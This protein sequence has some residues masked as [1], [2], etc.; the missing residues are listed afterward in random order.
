[1]ARLVKKAKDAEVWGGKKPNI[2]VICPPPIGEQMLTSSV[3]PIM[4]EHCVEKSRQLAAEY[5]KQCDLLGVYF[6]DAGKLGCE[7]NTVDYMHLTNKGHETL[8]R[9]LAERVAGYLG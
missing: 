5:E 2:L 4:G 9:G 6:L 8:A 1:M 7:F 3:A